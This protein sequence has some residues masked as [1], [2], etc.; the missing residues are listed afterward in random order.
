MYISIT[1]KA[2]HWNK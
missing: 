1:S 2:K